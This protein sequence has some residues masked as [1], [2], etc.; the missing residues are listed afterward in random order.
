MHMIRTFISVFI[1]L[2]DC[3]SYEER[4][5]RKDFWKSFRVFESSL[6]IFLEMELL[7]EIF[8]GGGFYTYFKQLLCALFVPFYRFHLAAWVDGCRRARNE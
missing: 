2:H 6:P 4:A 7:H 5:C 1:I 8:L 3:A